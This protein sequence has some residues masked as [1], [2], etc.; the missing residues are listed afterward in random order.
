[1][2]SE[3][4]L[5]E[6]AIN[7]SW[8]LR[9]VALRVQNLARSIEYYTQFGLSVVRDE[10]GQEN[11]TVGLGVGTQEVLQLRHLAQGKPRQRRSAGLYH[12]ALLL[13]DDAELGAFLQHCIEQRIPIAGAS[14]H[15][16]SQALYLSDPEGNG[17]EVYAD[18]PRE[19]WQFNQGLLVM[20]TLP[21]N[22]DNL[23]QQAKPF[24]GFSTGLRLGHMHLNVGNLERSMSFYQAL[25]M[26]LMIGIPRQ[27][28]FLS[29]DGYHH[30]LGI[31][32]WAGPNASPV[33]DDV[34]GIDF[35][36]I[37]RPE[38]SPATLQDPDGMTVVVS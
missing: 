21:L 18:R 25:G 32:T 24:K 12:F 17:I 8:P 1:M 11:G 4:I 26:N 23:L 9:R 14:D 36:E 20:D 27:A 33:T 2:N 15:L 16:V 38:L 30:H 35:F 22:I 19:G 37:H 34:Y 3:P 5:Q 29:W 28:D 6:I 7:T 10:S 13:P 31:N